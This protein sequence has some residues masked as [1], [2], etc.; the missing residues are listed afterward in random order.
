MKTAAAPCSKVEAVSE[1]ADVLGRSLDRFGG[2]EARRRREKEEREELMASAALGRRYKDEMDEE[3]AVAGHI[4]RSRKMLGEMFDQGA[5]ILA[6]MAGSR[7]R[8][9]VR[10]RA[11]ARRDP[12]FVLRLSAGERVGYGAPGGRQRHLNTAQ[13]SHRPFASLAFLPHPH[14]GPLPPPPRLTCP[15]APRHSLTTTPSQAAQKKML[16]VINSVGLGES[17]LRMIERRHKT[18]AYIAIGGMVRGRR[19]GWVLGG[20]WEGGRKGGGTGTGRVQAN[21]V[22]W[23]FCSCTSPIHYPDAEFPLSPASFQAVVVIFTVGLLWWAWH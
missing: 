8:I 18:D 16:D 9:K 10:A 19:A 4:G 3:A 5:G 21:T 7:E 23:C 1:E 14:H 12:A 17:V 15:L 22:A 11:R 6:G 20:F 13:R 2:R